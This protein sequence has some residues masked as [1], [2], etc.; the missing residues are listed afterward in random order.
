MKLIASVSVCGGHANS[1]WTDYRIA[2]YSITKT[3]LSNDN[4]DVSMD[5][6]IT[7][8]LQN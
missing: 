2:N 8:E 4:N 5:L 3:P 1:T 7:M 6:Q